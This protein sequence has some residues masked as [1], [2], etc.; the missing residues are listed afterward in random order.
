MGYEIVSVT[1]NTHHNVT[2]FMAYKALGDVNSF[3]MVPVAADEI[4]GQYAL[5][6]KPSYYLKVVESVV[7]KPLASTSPGPGARGM[8]Q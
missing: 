8:W 3:Q 4:P 7:L 1:E 6:S 5:S 2:P